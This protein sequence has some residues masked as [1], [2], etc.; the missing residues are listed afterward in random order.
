M[1]TKKDLRQGYNNIRIKEEYEW[2]ATFLMP[3]NVFE[4]TVMFFELTNSLATFQMIMNNLLN[5][6]I[7]VRDVAVFINDV[8]V[9][10]ETKEGYD[11]IAKEVL[12]RIAENHLFVKP[13]K[14]V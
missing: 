13:E 1:F 9:K 6:I 2:K 4:L 3:K 11:D 12:R 5:N 10:I 7:K 14:C 8:I